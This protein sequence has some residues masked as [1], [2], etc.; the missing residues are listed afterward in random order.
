M[1]P[2]PSFI[3]ILMS[4]KLFQAKQSTM[5]NWIAN[6]K[7]IVL[8][9]ENNSTSVYRKIAKSGYIHVFTSPKIAL[10]KKFKKNIFD[11]SSFTNKLH[12]LLAINKIHLVDQ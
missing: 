8:N 12:C 10:F 3:L 1:T 6:V 2:M 11:Q 4:L 9:R 7:L 5:I